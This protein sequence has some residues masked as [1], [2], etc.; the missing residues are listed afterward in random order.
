MNV[1]QQAIAILASVLLLSATA[2]GTGSAPDPTATPAIP[3]SGR[4]L[5]LGNGEE[6]SRAIFEF[7]EGMQSPQLLWTIPGGS[8]KSASKA[9]PMIIASPDHH[10]AMVVTDPAAIVIVDLTNGE[11]TN[12]DLPTRK[13]A[14]DSKRYDIAGNFSP[15]GRYLAYSLTGEN[16]THSGLYLY[17][18]TTHQVSTLFE[19]PCASYGGRTIEL[20][21][22]KVE[23][24]VWLDETTL[25]F[26]AFAGDPPK[27]QIGSSI[28]GNHTFVIDVNRT[29]IQEFADADNPSDMVW[30][31]SAAGP[32]ALAKGYAPPGAA[33][34]EGWV[35]AIDLKR[36]AARITP[37]QGEVKLLAPD[38]QSALRLEGK[39][40]HLTDLRGGT[41]IE[42]K[43]I[44]LG[45]AY[46][47]GSVCYSHTDITMGIP[48]AIS[49]SPDGKL[50]ACVSS[51]NVYVFSLA[52]LPVREIKW[53]DF[54]GYLVD[55]LP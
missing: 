30:L 8:L 32:T 48:P 18:L 11:T 22:G 40:W 29:P 19:G 37:L 54:Y 44:W 42:L 55:W 36:R 52:G 45:V 7:K 39:T 49:W 20:V 50:I 51:A 33:F 53:K 21:C 9:E 34:A 12:I 26:H 35:E 25:V 23:R 1:K 15:N 17:D 16:A 38:G 28:P 41:D 31:D 5:L 6:N 43:E 13:Y 14:S 4:I 27:T 24:P 2:C 10:Y 46:P 3:L 47:S